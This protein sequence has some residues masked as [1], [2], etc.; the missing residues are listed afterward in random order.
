MGAEWDHRYH[1]Y[2]ATTTITL[3]PS[4]LTATATPATTA[5]PIAKLMMTLYFPLVLPTPVL[6]HQHHASALYIDH[7]NICTT[8]GGYRR[9]EKSCKAAFCGAYVHVD[10]MCITLLKIGML[11][12]LL[13]FSAADARLLRPLKFLS[14]NLVNIYLRKQDVI[15]DEENVQY[16]TGSVL[17]NVP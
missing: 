4:Q 16:N 10:N 5:T 3:L 14:S 9:A 17:L 2:I 12:S 1:H 13:F 11:L 6:N 15:D 7:M 8:N